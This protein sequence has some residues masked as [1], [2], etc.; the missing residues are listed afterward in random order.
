MAQDSRRL[1]IS[2]ASAMV[3]SRV[4]KDQD[5]GQQIMG[6][7]FTNP[8]VIGVVAGII[9]MLGVIPGMPALVFLPVAGGWA[10]APGS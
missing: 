8:K 2:V 6:Q 1:L 4:G 9:G 10:M 5:V 3:V 7:M